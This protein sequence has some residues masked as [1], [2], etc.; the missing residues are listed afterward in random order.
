M[1]AAVHM[2]H[3]YIVCRKVKCQ[4]TQSTNQANF[5]FQRYGVDQGI[6]GQSFSLPTHVYA[7]AHTHTYIC[8][9]GTWE[10]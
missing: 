4:M 7:F 9:L 1:H 10:A 8:T 5:I 2:Q 3:M 6:A